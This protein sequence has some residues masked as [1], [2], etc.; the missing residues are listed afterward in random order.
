MDSVSKPYT[1]ENKNVVCV[2]KDIGANINRSVSKSVSSANI[3]PVLLAI[4]FNIECSDIE[5][6]RK[7]ELMVDANE[8]FGIDTRRMW[9]H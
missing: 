5:C 3:V 7:A 1:R 2:R 8:D 4:R 9:E 6:V